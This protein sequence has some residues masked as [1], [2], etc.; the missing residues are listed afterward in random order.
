[1][2]GV[3]LGLLWVVLGWR[4]VGVLG[5]RGFLGVVRFRVFCS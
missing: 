1:M 4:F 5:G 2:V 3:V